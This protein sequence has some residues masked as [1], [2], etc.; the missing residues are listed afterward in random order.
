[1][2]VWVPQSGWGHTGVT[3]P[4]DV[5][6]G[7]GSGVAAAE[8]PVPM[9]MHEAMDA[10][11]FPRLE[12]N[13]QA[14][15]GGLLKAGMWL[16]SSIARMRALGLLGESTRWA[17]ASERTYTMFMKAYL[18]SYRL[19]PAVSGYEVSNFCSVF[20]PQDAQEVLSAASTQFWHNSDLALVCHSGGWGLT[21]LPHRTA[22]LAGTRT[23]RNR[24][25]ESATPRSAAC[26]AS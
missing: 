22:S 25:Q 14:F 9:L 6:G 15:E 3:P 7:L 20:V 8:L 19:D 13:L 24:N 4:R 18:E 5:Q 12:S 1:M 17:L 23:I 10:R 21:G 16:N 2:D 26:R 11:T